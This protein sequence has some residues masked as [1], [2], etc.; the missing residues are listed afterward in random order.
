MRRQTTSPPARRAHG[1][2]LVGDLGARGDRVGGVAGGVE[3]QTGTDIATALDAAFLR[4]AAT[5]E[6]STNLPPGVEVVIPPGRFRQSA[7][8]DWRTA[9]S[10]FPYY[11]LRGEGERAEIFLDGGADGGPTK[12][13]VDGNVNKLEVDHLVVR[14]GV[15]LGAALSVNNGHSWLFAGPID[16]YVHD[17]DVHSARFDQAFIWSEGQYVDIRRL[18]SWGGGGVARGVIC[19]RMWSVANI[20]DCHAQ[21]DFGNYDAGVTGTFGGENGPYFVD[22]TE[23]RPR[24]FGAPGQG[25]L[26]VKGSGFDE[27]YLAFV[28]AGAAGQPRIALV[29]IEDVHGLL[30]A[31]DGS[32]VGLITN[33]DHA[34]FDGVFVE[35]RIPDRQYLADLY[36]V[37]TATFRHCGYHDE[38]GGSTGAAIRTDSTTRLVE[39]VD[40][41]DGLDLSQVHANTRVIWRREVR[42]RWCRATGVTAGRLAKRGAGGLVAMGTA[43]DGALA[44]AVILRFDSQ[45]GSN[46][47]LAIEERGQVVEVQKDAGAVTQDAAAYHAQA[48]G[49]E[50][51]FSATA[52]GSRVGWF[53]ESSAGAAGTVVKVRFG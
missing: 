31:V 12:W 41:D 27:R 32:S 37:S 23:V 43:D 24:T 21:W 5:A 8:S 20:T 22:A 26:T 45:L 51:R 11:R 18:N 14:N 25:V 10:G 3:T 4:A 17:I 36:D 34:I 46:R 7:F 13:R 30:Q 33:T 44:D 52:S 42:A 47:A 38:G 9:G 1:L 40:C 28:R 19:L 48:A 53:E 15:P 50:G 6:A 29:K 2:D 39:L 49:Q 16:L 35:T